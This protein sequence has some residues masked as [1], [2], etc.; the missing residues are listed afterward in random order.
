MI[1]IL[2]G[3][4]LKES[5]KLSDE[6]LKKV[7]E[8]QKKV[9]VKLG[10]IAVSEKMM[11]IEQADEVNN[12]Q[13][14]MDMRFGDIAISKGYLTD[15]QVG[16]L[17]SMQGNLYLSFVQVITNENFMTIEEIEQAYL[18]FQKSLNFTQTEMDRLKSGEADLLIPLFLPLN[19]D[20]Y[21]KEYILVAVKTLIRLIDN[22]LYIGKAEWVSEIEADGAAL[23]DIKGDAD[24][25]LS[26]AGCGDSLLP[27]ASKFA[28]EEF[29]AVDADALDAVAELINCINGM[30]ASDC[31]PKFFVDMLPPIYKEGKNTLSAAQICVLPVF[32]KG[33]QVNV[34]SVFRGKLS[35]K[36]VE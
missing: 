25:T 6:Q 4:F 1:H 33:K 19:I 11:T 9:R 2:F 13:S 34:L 26:F 21:H 22:D 18:E 29:E 24:A 12:L 17:L 16:H 30:F 3:N 28:G 8:E 15:E 27:I 32:I 36:G 5:G 10:L 20:D 7:Y 14:T 23:Q 31:S 35:I